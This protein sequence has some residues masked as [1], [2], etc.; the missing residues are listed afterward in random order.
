MA[1]R[2]PRRCTGGT[3]AALASVALL[4]AVLIEGPMAAAPAAT[5]G[6][7]LGG[8][9]VLSGSPGTPVVNA[10]THTLYVPIQSGSVLDVVNDAACNA[11]VQ[12]G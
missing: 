8:S 3:L 7:A 1:S 2:Q 12:S 9:V 4:V 5:A 10:E 6:A 11:N